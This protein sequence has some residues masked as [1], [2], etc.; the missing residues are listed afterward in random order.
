MNQQ[1]K[2]FLHSVVFVAGFTLV[3]TIIGI[4]L[5]TIFQSVFLETSN[6]LRIV[7]GSIIVLFGILLLASLKYNI[8]FLQQEHKLKIKRL[9][10]S[11]LT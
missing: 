7:G 1:K 3:F 2:L 11:Y 8:P 4:L 6:I 5:Q 10:N 9:K